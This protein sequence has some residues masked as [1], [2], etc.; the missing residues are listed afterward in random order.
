MLP[1]AASVA[2]AIGDL[3]QRIADVESNIATLKREIAG[4]AVPRHMLTW[5]VDFVAGTEVK[6]E[7]L[8][9]RRRGLQR[10]RDNSIQTVLEGRNTIVSRLGGNRH[11]CAELAP[12]QAV[13]RCS[14]VTRST[15]QPRPGFASLACLLECRLADPAPTLYTFTD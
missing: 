13:R 6:L 14:T 11:R 3:D 12:T 15:R 7:E 5:L 4:H 2:E 1:P 9:G 10:R 8:R